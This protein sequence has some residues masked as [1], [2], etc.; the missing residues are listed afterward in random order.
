MYAVLRGKATYFYLTSDSIAYTNSVLRIYIIEWNCVAIK[1]LKYILRDHYENAEDAARRIMSTCVFKP[2]KRPEVEYKDLKKHFGKIYRDHTYMWFNESIEEEI[3]APP[4]AI[5]EIDKR[6]STDDIRF[7]FSCRGA[8]VYIY[9]S[10]IAIDINGDRV[11]I[12]ADYILFHWGHVRLSRR[13]LGFLA[14]FGLPINANCYYSARE[15]LLKLAAVSA[16]DVL[17]GPISEEIYPL[18]ETKYDYE[19]G[20]FVYE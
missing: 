18:M 15:E 11:V 6:G 13:S 9:R 1:C 2:P 19:R 17:P 10:A 8:D 3:I 12:L 14:D 7:Y 4:F 20:E 5:V 16:L